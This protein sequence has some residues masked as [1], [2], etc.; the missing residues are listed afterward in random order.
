[1]QRFGASDAML[2]DGGGSSCMVLRDPY[3]DTY[4][5]VNSPDDGHLRDMFNSILVVK[6]D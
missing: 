1:M 6:K 2:L 5:T 3:T 4:T